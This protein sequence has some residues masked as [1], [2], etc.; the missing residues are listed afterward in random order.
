MSTEEAKNNALSGVSPEMM[1]QVGKHDAIKEE[2]NV[3][4]EDVSDMK[5]ALK[6]KFKGESGSRE[7]HM[8]FFGGAIAP[9]PDSVKK[10]EK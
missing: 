4:K 2:G 10:T 8:N 9:L 5:E 1:K 7:I 6:S 3:S